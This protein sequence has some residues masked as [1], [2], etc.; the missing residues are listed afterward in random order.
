M[1]RSGGPQQSA[2]AARQAADRLRDATNLLGGTQQQLASGKVD[3]LSH[4]ADRLTQEERAQADRIDKLASQ[5]GDSGTMDRDSMMARLRERD[6]LAGER[7]QLSNDL[8]KLQKGVREA[9]REMAPNQPGVAQKLRD[10]LT[11]MDQSDLDNHVQRTADWLRGGINPNSNG[12]ES[13]IA[14]GLQK[15]SQQLRQAQQGIGQGKPGQRGAAQGDETAALSQV[16]R[17]RSQLEAMASSRRG[18]GGS[19]ARMG[20]GQQGRDGQQGQNNQQGQNGNQQGQ[21][22]GRGAAGNGGQ[23]V[24]PGCNRARMH[25]AAHSR[26]AAL[27]SRRETNA[28]VRAVTFAMAAEAARMAPSGAISIPATTA[29]AKPGSGRR[30]LTPPAIPPIRSA[31]ISRAY[32]N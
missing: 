23:Q 22:N 29:M 16:E 13:E 4:E 15:L 6:R 26:A 24:V 9:A 14:Q 2:E 8:S 7:Q 21:A 10:A 18:N 20:K 25:K 31:P 28:A 27:A 1:K 5:Q 12:T 32:V 11:E 3:S 30:R 19:R 17:L